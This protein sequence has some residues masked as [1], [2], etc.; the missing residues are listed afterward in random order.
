MARA[1]A[2]W[3][4]RKPFQG[5]IARA[6]S[7]DCLAIEQ[8][9]GLAQW[10][11]IERID[12]ATAETEPRC[13]AVT[14]AW[15]YGNDDCLLSDWSVG[16][17]PD[18][19]AYAQAAQTTLE[20]ELAE[21]E[22]KIASVVPPASPAAADLQR[23]ADLKRE[24][25]NLSQYRYWQE[26]YNPFGD[27]C[28]ALY[29]ACNAPN[30]PFRLRSNWRL[31]P[32]RPFT[33]LLHRMKPHQAQQESVLRIRF[34]HWCLELRQDSEVQLYRYKDGRQWVPATATTRGHWVEY[35]GTDWAAIDAIEAQMRA[36]QDTGRLTAQDRQ[37]IAEW[38]AEIQRLDQQI[39]A[40][41]KD[42]SLSK[43]RVAE[44]KK[45]LRDQ[46]GQYRD[47]IKAL[48]SQKSGIT[49]AI[50]TELEALEASYLAARETVNFQHMA[51]SL[52]GSDVA[53][54]VIPQPR[55][56]LLLHCSQGK[57]YWV[58]E[59]REVTSRNEEA[60]LVAGTPVEIS[61]NGGALWFR[62]TYLR[63]ARSGYLESG[64]LDTGGPVR[65]MKSLAIQATTPVGTTATGTVSEEGTGY[66]WRVDLGSESGYLPFLYRIALDLEATPRNRTAETLE[67]DSRTA[68]VQWDVGST[69]DRENRGRA[70]TLTLYVPDDRVAEFAGYANHQVQLFEG[71][72]DAWFTGQLCEPTFEQHAKGYTKLSFQ[73][74]DRWALMRS[75][76]M[77][78]EPAGDGKTLLAYLKQI[79]RGLGLHED[80]MVLSGAGLSRRLPTTPPNQDRALQPAYGTV[81]ADWVEQ[82]LEDF[83]YFYDMWF[84]GAGRWHVEPLGTVTKNAT[85]HR[86]ATESGDRR[87]MANLRRSD[88]WDEFRNDFT[89]LGATV[90]G[91]R[92]S[93]RYQD[94]AS[95]NDP[96]CGR[97]VGRWIAAEPYQSD[98]LTTQALV[99]ACLRWRV[100][101]YLLPYTELTWECGYD[102]D[103]AV[104][105][106]VIADGHTVEILELRA[107]S[108]AEDRMTVVA[109][110]V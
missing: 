22:Q 45:G 73:C 87:V 7:L 48:K 110:A 26:V 63:P 24:I 75:D 27:G 28:W 4:I 62:F 104:G 96:G 2:Y 10:R 60:V 44:L 65:P 50:E 14:L 82:L 108:R 15:S 32:D 52:I 36:L 19:E 76:V 78:G 38:N 72:G 80:E 37:Q 99:N 51:E 12:I 91:Q 41:S 29:R 42:A 71:A 47:R 90:Q 23:R 11:N 31:Q 13:Q 53:I 103:L 89:V 30:I 84:D 46:Q 33:L 95:V 109:R 25:E 16:E 98:S 93:A 21:V 107:D 9:E 17:A 67:A 34:G 74:R 81:R 35:K 43:D 1:D 85:F 66:R 92:L 100:Y 20:T 105:D 5:P 39:A 86:T 40:L 61:G 102:P 69:F 106:R 3:Q 64:P 8:W 59:D 94:Y 54:T 18:E 83:L 57:D 77:A 49:P 101:R 88:L 6:Y 97:Y 70:A 58:Y 68:G 79:G 55:G 56:Y